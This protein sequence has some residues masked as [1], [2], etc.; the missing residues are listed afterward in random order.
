M[1]K[2]TNINPTRHKHTMPLNRQ[3]SKGTTSKWFNK[4]QTLDMAF[5][6]IISKYSHLSL[7][8]KKHQELLLLFCSKLINK[9][10]N[11]TII[12]ILCILYFY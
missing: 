5:R 11:D 3:D 12:F 7:I 9:I 1:F 10:T 4:I 6:P 8:M 2:A